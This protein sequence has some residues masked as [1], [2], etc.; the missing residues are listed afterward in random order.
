[1]EGGRQIGRDIGGSAA[2]E[3]CQGNH[4][5]LLVWPVSKFGIEA[6]NPSSML[7]ALVPI[8][9]RDGYAA[10]ILVFEGRDHVLKRRRFQYPAAK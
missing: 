2:V 10:S 8:Y 9:G 3:I 6:L 7:Y 4:R 1:M 5:H